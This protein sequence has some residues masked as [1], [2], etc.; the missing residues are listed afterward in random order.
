VERSRQTFDTGSGLV[1]QGVLE[2]PDLLRSGSPRLSAGYHSRCTEKLQWQPRCGIP[3]GIQLS[4]LWE[5]SDLPPQ[6]GFTY[7]TMA[8][9]G[10][11][12]CV[13]SSAW[14]VTLRR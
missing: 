6:R 5:R 1:K 4:S 7:D 14:L 12:L 2:R 9:L 13:I 3:L 11:H 8:K 10:P